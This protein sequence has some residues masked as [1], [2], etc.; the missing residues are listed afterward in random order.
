VRW[1]KTGDQVCKTGTAV[2]C[3]YRLRRRL[4]RGVRRWSCVRLNEIEGAFEGTLFVI[5]FFLKLKDGV[6]NGFG[7]RRAARDVDVDWEHLIA[8]LNDGVIVEDAAGSGA[9]T[10]GDDPLG[11]GHLIVELA[12]DGSHFLREASGDDH[13]VG[14]ARRG[15]ENFGAEARDV[16]TGGGHRHHFNGAAGES[17]TEGPDRAAARPVHGFVERRED[18]AFVFE[19]LAEVVWLGEGDVLA[20]RCAHWASRGYFRTSGGE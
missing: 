12:N 4:E 15:A 13:E 16:E 18:N 20:E 7:A 8:A 17:E 9:G 1:R 3:P 5:D 19:E 10:H 2:P 14:L 11:F 6:E